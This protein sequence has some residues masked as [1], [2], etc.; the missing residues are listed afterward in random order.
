MNRKTQIFIAATI[1]SGACLTGACLFEELLRGGFL[2]YPAFLVPALLGAMLKVR[3][4]G[5]KSTI[6]LNFLFT[7]ISI[8][9][10]TFAETVL[11]AGVTCVIQCLWRPRTRPTAVQVL[12]NAA[13]LEISSGAAYR[14][15]HAAAP[16]ANIIALI[17][18]A[19]CIYLLIDTLLISGVLSL[20][21]GKPLRTVWRQCYEWAFPYYAA[22]AVLAGL[23][24]ETNRSEGWLPALLVLIPMVFVYAFYSLCANRTA[25]AGA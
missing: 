10:F 3:L 9:L 20:I 14:L 12:F 6:S 15:S 8:A 24:V 23:M 18:L 4:P 17:A 19:G 5:I 1:A 7:L 16:G 22:G 25:T 13:V 21:Q 2:S 11:L